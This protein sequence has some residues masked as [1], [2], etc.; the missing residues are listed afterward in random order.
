[1]TT[2]LIAYLVMDGNAREAIQFY[3]QALDAKLMFQQ[4]FGEMPENPDFPLPAES[5]E[6]IAHAML[7]VGES[8]LMLSDTFPG[9]PHQSGNQVTICISTKDKESAAKMFDALSQ[10]GN[11]GM[12]LQETHFSPAYG[13]VTDKFGVGF[14]VFTEGMM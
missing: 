9:H 5:K 14:Q 13:S 7:K 12:P 11:V 8:D 2:R 6:R 3:V 1:M 4:T 10:G